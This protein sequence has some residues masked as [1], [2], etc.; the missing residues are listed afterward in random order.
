MKRVTLRKTSIENIVSD[1]GNFDFMATDWDC[2]FLDQ[3]VR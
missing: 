2:T 1:D 3:I